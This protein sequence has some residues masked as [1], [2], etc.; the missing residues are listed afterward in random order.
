MTETGGSA[1]AWMIH[2]AQDIVS[3]PLI[4][5]TPPALWSP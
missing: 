4:A 2:F 5:L 1:W 3:F